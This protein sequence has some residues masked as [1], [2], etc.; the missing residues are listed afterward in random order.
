[1][2][3]KV[4]RSFRIELTEEEAKDF[5]QMMEDWHAN[6][7]PDA[8]ILYAMEDAITELVNGE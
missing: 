2:D 6:R 5:L 1:M 8:T 3:V 7:P 4:V